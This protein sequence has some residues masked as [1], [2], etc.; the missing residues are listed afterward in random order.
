[1]PIRILILLATAFLLTGCS[2]A[3]TAPSGSS[4]KVPCS[5]ATTAPS[6]SSTKVPFTRKELVASLVARGDQLFGKGEKWRAIYPYEF[7]KAYSKDD[8]EIAKKLDSVKADRSSASLTEEECS[9]GIDV[10]TTVPNDREDW[11]PPDPGMQLVELR[12]LSDIRLVGNLQYG[13]VNTTDTKGAASLPQQMMFAAKPKIKLS[14][15]RS[16]YGDP[17]ASTNYPDGWV[18]LTYGRIRIFSTKTGDV[19]VVFFR[20]VILE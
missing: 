4:T 13:V 11:P 1:M 16:T 15:V 19:E 20:R 2:G 18:A 14:D 7:A 5:G 9:H 10:L 8:A 3:T 12:I 17:S 6:G